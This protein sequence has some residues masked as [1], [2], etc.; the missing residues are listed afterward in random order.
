[1][2][3]LGISDTTPRSDG[4]LK[5]LFWPS[6]QSG[7]DVDYLGSQGYW[8]C[9]MVALVSFAFL[10]GLGQPIMAFTVLLFYYMSGVGVRERSRYVAT[11]VFVVFL[12]GLVESGPGVVN[13]LLSAL[14]LS[15]L[16]TCGAKVTWETNCFSVGK[17]LKLEPYSLS[18]TSTVSTP[19]AS[20]CVMST[21]LIRYNAWRLA[22]CP[23]FLIIFALLLFGRGG[24]IWPRCSSRSISPSLRTI[25][26]SYAAIRSCTASYIFRACCKLN[27]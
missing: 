8:V 4:R 12:A 13:I 15:L 22:S 19:M 2:Q 1:M 23:R 20:I 24:A 27:K 16:G 11:M 26:C 9:A 3:T 6:I 21:P 25:S 17:R 5:S 14:L 18:T 10:I 7:A